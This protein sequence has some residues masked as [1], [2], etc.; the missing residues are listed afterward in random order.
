[1]ANEIL[2]PAD[3]VL[4]MLVAAYKAGFEGPMEMSEET[5]REIMTRSTYDESDLSLMRH[6]QERASRYA[7]PPSAPTSN[8]RRPTAAGKY[9][10]KPAMYQPNYENEYDAPDHEA[11]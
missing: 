1:M 2:Y 11:G 9:L 4:K 7:A 8:A 10:P 5:C 3:A 6:M